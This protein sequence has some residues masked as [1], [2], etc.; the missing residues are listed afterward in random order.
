MLSGLSQA[1]PPDFI[2]KAERPRR[3][4]NDQPDQAV[5]PFFF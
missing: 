4:I 2:G 5:A 3:M 1:A